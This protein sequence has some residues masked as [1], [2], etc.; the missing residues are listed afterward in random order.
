VASS[1]DVNEAAVRAGIDR[2]GGACVDRP[3]RTVANRV[4]RFRIAI[5]SSLLKALRDDQAFRHLLKI[6]LLCVNPREATSGHASV[7]LDLCLTIRYHVRGEWT[8]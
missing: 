3:L 5:P 7:S 8:V 6:C 4:T 2:D 1:A